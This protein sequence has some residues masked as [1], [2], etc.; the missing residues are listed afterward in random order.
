MDDE[1]KYSGNG[2]VRF[3]NGQEKSF[4]AIK[5]VDDIQESEKTDFKIE[6]VNVDG[7]GE[8]GEQTVQ[9]ITVENDIRKCEI[10]DKYRKNVFMTL[11]N[12]VFIFFL[13]SN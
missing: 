8:L 1:G 3:V 4:V 6:L 9:N 2:S 13:K 7:N 5:M 12:N 11:E 10:K